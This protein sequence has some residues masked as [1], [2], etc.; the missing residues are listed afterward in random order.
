MTFEIF[1][2]FPITSLLIGL[3]TIAATS[4]FFASLTARSIDVKIDLTLDKF[5]F[6]IVY[7][8]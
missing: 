8:Y 2:F 7:F 1:D 4:P 5:F 6:L 3:V